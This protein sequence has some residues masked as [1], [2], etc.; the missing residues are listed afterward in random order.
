M[1]AY[2]CEE[3]Y[4]TASQSYIQSHPVQEEPHGVNAEEVGGPHQQPGQ[5]HQVL[6]SG[7]RRVHPMAQ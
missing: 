2:F 3:F 6:A 5:P 1:T 7:A 4:L